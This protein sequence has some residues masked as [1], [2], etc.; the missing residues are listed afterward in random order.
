VVI[1]IDPPA[2]AVLCAFWMIWTVRDHLSI[3]TLVPSK[4]H[5]FGGDIAWCSAQS[6]SGWNCSA[7]N[8]SSGTAIMTI[9]PMAESLDPSS[10]QMPG[11]ALNEWK[12]SVLSLMEPFA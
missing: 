3:S 8:N 11:S 10:L 2:D 9:C 4:E 12:E 5:S 6:P 7:T 1:G